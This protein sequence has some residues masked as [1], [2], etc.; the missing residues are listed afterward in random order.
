MTAL[1][2][3]GLYHLVFRGTLDLTSQSKYLNPNEFDVEASYA[4]YVAPPDLS[5]PA[6]MPTL[7]RLQAEICRT[8]ELFKPE[9][10]I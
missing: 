7:R 5:Q 8:I 2:D 4:I 3:A 6:L 1:T 10:P 9:F